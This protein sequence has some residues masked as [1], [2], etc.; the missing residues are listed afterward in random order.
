MFWK[1]PLPSCCIRLSGVYS[2]SYVFAYNQPPPPPNLPNSA[3]C[4]GFVFHQN[5]QIPRTHEELGSS[6]L[7]A[8]ADGTSIVV[9]S[10]D[11]P[12]QY[13]VALR[14]RTRPLTPPC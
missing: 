6:N 14:T 7:I 2:G 8:G 1:S 13:A 9:D 4:N 10:V 3:V 11:N 12:W 5:A